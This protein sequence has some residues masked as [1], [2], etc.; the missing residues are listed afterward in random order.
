MTA[1]QLD[2]EGLDAEA[3]DILNEM[4]AG[5]GEAARLWN[6]LIDQ[7]RADTFAAIMADFYKLGGGFRALLPTL[8]GSGPGMQKARIAEVRTAAAIL[9]IARTITEQHAELKGPGSVNKA[10]FIIEQ[11]GANYELP[12]SITSILSSWRKYK[13]VSHLACAVNYCTGFSIYKDSDRLTQIAL[14][15]AVANWLESGRGSVHLK[16]ALILF[17]RLG[18]DVRSLSARE[19]SLAYLQLA[20]R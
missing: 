20:R 18:V 4:A 2:A 6:E 8:Q 5:E 19:F 10:V 13:Y 7:V 12:T 3:V 9:R 1:E 11:T 14:F 17:K 16:D 15:L